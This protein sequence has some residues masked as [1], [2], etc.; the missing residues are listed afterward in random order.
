MTNVHIL[1]RASEHNWG[2]LG[3]G[4]WEKKEWTVYTDGSFRLTVSYRP[5]DL[6]EEDEV[7]VGT[8]RSDSFERL[9]EL[10][11]SPWSDQKTEACDGTAW[12]FRLL[13]DRG[14]IISRRKLGYI[15]GIEPFESIVHILG[16]T[17]ETAYHVPKEP[18]KKQRSKEQPVDYSSIVQQFDTERKPWQTERK[19]GQENMPEKAPMVVD[20][21]AV[22][23]MW[24]DP[25]SRILDE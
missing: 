24:K 5:T 18:L 16:I 8:I 15:Y 7:K 11:Y 19:E 14:R 25:D 17:E 6:P 10:L 2:L 21:M 3:P 9:I 22:S 4:D 1:L 12:E 13:G 20:Y 23:E